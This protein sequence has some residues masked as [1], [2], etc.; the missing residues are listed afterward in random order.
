MSSQ[1]PT[2]AELLRTPGG[3]LTSSHLRE[4][5]WT[6]RHIDAIW[7]ACP[8]IILPGTRRPVLRVEHY[9]AYL[10]EHTYRNEQPRVVPSFE[11]LTGTPPT[12]IARQ[13]RP[14]R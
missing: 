5:G 7:R 8:M 13:R 4:L 2:A 3:V 14:S 9:L 6:R 10:E 12:K 11:P 1:N